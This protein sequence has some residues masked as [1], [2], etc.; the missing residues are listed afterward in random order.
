MFKLQGFRFSWPLLVILA[1]V[2]SVLE[3]IAAAFIY[4]LVG[5]AV[6]PSASMRLPVF[7][8]IQI[9]N[10]EGGDRTVTL[11]FVL[12]MVAFFLL[13]ALIALAAEYITSRVANN[14]AARISSRLA[15]G[16]M[17]LPYSY[18]LQHNSSELIRNTQQAV[19]TVANHIFIPLGRVVA[20][21]V[22]VVGILVLLVLVSPMATLFA[23]IVVSGSTIFLMCVV[24]PRMRHLGKIG[25]IVQKDTLLALQE[26]FEGVRDIKVMGREEY[27]TKSYKV[28]IRRLV[29]IDYLWMTLQHLPRLVIETSL[30]CFILAYLAYAVFS[31]VEA[32][33]TLSVLGL[34]GYAGLRLQPSLQK[35]AA[36]FN[37]I[38]FS[39]ERVADIY[40]D[41]RLIEQY[42]F[43]DNFEET[44]T[45]EHEIK[46]ENVSFAYE[47][48]EGMALSDVNLSIQHGEQIGICGSTGGGKSTLVDIIVGLLSPD[49]GRILVD[50][51][52]IA[53]C[54]RAWQQ[55][56]G[57]VSQTVFLIDD[58]LRNN[59]ALGIPSEEIDEFAIAR[60][61]KQAQLESFIEVLPDGLDTIVGERGVRISG[62]E[63]QR[64]AIA[65][66][67]YRQ[68]AVLIFDEGTSALDNA[69]EQEFMS[70]MASLR[71]KH[72]IILVAHRLSTVC[73]AD[74]VVFLERGRVAGCDT[75]DNLLAN[76]TAFRQMAAMS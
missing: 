40:N 32:R 41:L 45:F 71:G 34:F 12:G 2:S 8:D 57:V 52:D 53:D 46:I 54:T 14:T 26:S 15:E 1:L 66:A 18:H 44:L 73:D 56:L 68:P 74:R 70:A 51:K 36:G 24:Q 20:E 63:R 59:I 75:F 76:N 72:T 33:E 38:K 64:I 62:G 49:R 37:S 9:F 39:A 21:A 7:G 47:G 43:I 16:Y 17:R 61:V 60:A 35:I 19:L 22:M 5:A 10:T 30:I 4:V 42:D 58:S 6:N 23:V 11:I 27:F 3:I 31:G 25:H 65:R 48:A 28:A 13:R 67:L 69:T 50:N 29:R 55:N